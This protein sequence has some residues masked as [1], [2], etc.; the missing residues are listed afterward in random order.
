MIKM[1]FKI[2][3]L[4]SLIFASSASAWATMTAQDYFQAGN[5]YYTQGKYD[6]AIRC[7]R[8]AVQADPQNWHFYQDLGSCEYR[9]GQR[10]AALQ[11]YRTS[12]A[13]N[14]N[15]PALQK[16]LTRISAVAIPTVMPSSTPMVSA[17]TAKKIVNALPK[18]G[19]ITW[20]VMA[21]ADL[22][23]YD[24]FADYYGTGL[25]GTDTL[26]GVDF[27]LGADY[28][29]APEFQ[30]GLN[31]EGIYKLTQPVSFTAGSE[32]EVDTWTD[33]CLG[34]ALDMKYLIPLDRQISFILHG[35]LGYY[36][37]EGSTYDYAV[38]G[39]LP[40]T[41]IV[42][43]SGTSL[44]EL[45]GFE[46]E[47]M[48]GPGWAI[49]FGLGYR[50]LQFTTINFSAKNTLGFSNSGVLTTENNSGN[51]YIDFSGFNFTTALRFF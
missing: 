51:S 20:N 17:Q 36:F 8:A 41:G 29:I 6:L 45:L 1:F 11:D 9:L 4:L 18:P 37:L 25:I 15:N 49:D 39:L 23:S 24:D 30:L 12:L 48:T 50:F 44:G 5:Y 32:T 38:T 34:P 26:I 22:D 21:G 3:I 46:V 47:W 31:A 7:F 35:E 10:D 2:I 40:F 33:L 43:L 16:F 14:P 27:G 42:N 19:S 28:T 13:L